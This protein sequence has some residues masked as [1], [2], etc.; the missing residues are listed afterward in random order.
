MIIIQYIRPQSKEAR[1]YDMFAYAYVI[2]PLIQQF[3]SQYSVLA[4]K[5]AFSKQMQE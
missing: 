5:E 4:F 1:A 2:L 3:V